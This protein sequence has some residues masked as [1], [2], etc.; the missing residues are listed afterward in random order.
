MVFKYNPFTNNLDDAG[1]S[2]SS[3]PTASSIPDGQLISGFDGTVQ[4]YDPL[5]HFIMFDDF[6][7][8]YSH[9]WLAWDQAG[10][11]NTFRQNSSDYEYAGHPGVQALELDNTAEWGVQKLGQYGGYGGYVPGGGRTYLHWVAKIG[12]LSDATRDFKVKIGIQNA[13]SATWENGFWFEYNHGVNSGNWVSVVDDGGTQSTGNSSTAADTDFHT[14]SIEINAAGTSIK[15]S[16]DG[17]ELANSPITTNIPITNMAPA[18]G[19]ELTAG[20]GTKRYLA[21]DQFYMYQELTTTR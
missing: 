18:I 11:G 6:F 5:K 14:F 12:T 7:T 8:T 21:W 2:G 17:T 4:W 16:I 9:S 3:F 13:E 20:D 10:S 1:S 19:M 15:F